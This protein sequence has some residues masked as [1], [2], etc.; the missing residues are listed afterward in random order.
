MNPLAKMR[1]LVACGLLVLLTAC[2]GGGKQSLPA[3]SNAYFDT[4]SALWVFSEKDVWAAGSR[5]LHFDGSK[6]AEVAPPAMGVGLS[7]FFGLAPDDLWATSGTTIYRWRGATAGWSTVQHNIPGAPDFSTIWVFG[8]DDYVVGGGAVNQEIIRVKG[9]TIR[10]AYTYGTP[11]GIWAANGDD[12]W[13]MADHS[14]GGFW[15]WNGTTWSKVAPTGNNGDRP[16]GVWGF[17]SNDV[18][19]A[20]E[21]D[22][23]QHWDGSMWTATNLDSLDHPDLTAVWGSSTKDVYAVGDQG[24]VLHFDGSKWSK[25]SVGPSVFF[26][27]V[28]GSSA[29]SV[30][31][32]GY[33][34]STS[35]NHGVVFRL[36]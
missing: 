13:T 17:A 12:I 1:D 15:H 26:T 35:G 29:K 10:R 28:H 25:S 30:W 9:S 24:D 31:G 36:Q 22:T 2:G 34:L 21:Q 18:W 23:L 14:S 11:R 20:G 33:E 32:L 6:W 8:P 27:A 5:I 19:A 4:L 16:V 7:A 3:A